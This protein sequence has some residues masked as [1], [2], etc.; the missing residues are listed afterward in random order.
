MLFAF[1][2][3]AP[4]VGPTSRM[5]QYA[6]TAWRIQ[7]GVFTGA[8]LSITQT[9]DGYIWIGTQTGL[10]RFDGVRF[11]PW[12][13]PEGKRLLSSNSIFSLLADR[14]GSLWIGTGTDLAHWV[15]GDLV[16][17]SNARGRINA[18]RQD[19]NGTVWITRS[20]VREATGPLCEVRGAE[21]VCHGS[22][23]GFQFPFAQ[24]LALD[25]E[26]NYWV[27]GSSSLARWRAGSATV[28]TPVSLKG[29]AGLSGVQGLAAGP[30]GT[31]WVGMN[32]A[33]PGLGL[34]QF[35]NGAWAPF[36]TEGFDGSKLAVTALF[37]DRSN[38]L[39]IG[40]DN[41]GIYRIR[42]GKVDGFSSADG[43]SSDTVQSFYE[44]REGDLW[45]VTSEGIDCFRSTRILSFSTR[46]GLTANEVNSVI[47]ARDGNVWFGNQGALDYLRQ[48]Q[49][50]SIRPDRG[51]PGA[52]VTAMM[53]DHAGQLWVGVDD[54]LWINHAGKFSAVKHADGVPTGAVISLAEDRNNVVWALPVANPA[55]LLRIEGLV[56]QD[57]LAEAKLPRISSLATDRAEGIW[58]GLSTGELTRY[59][60]GNLETYKFNQTEPTAIRQLTV[61]AD[62][63]VW[64]STL[65]GLVVWKNGALRN[66]RVQN[67]LPCDRIF[68]SVTDRENDLW[69]YSECGLVRID[70][71]ELNSWWENPA[72]VLHPRLFDVFDG[73]RPAIPAFQ[74]IAS[75]APDGRLWFTNETIA[76]VIDPA[77][78]EKNELP[79]PVHI[80][81][82]VANRQSYGLGSKIS[83][84]PRIRDLQIDYTALSFVVPQKVL[85]RYKLEGHD[86][87]WQDA[88]TRRQAFYTD[89][90]PGTYRFHVIACNNDGVW[91]EVG[92]VLEFII[93]PAWYQTIWFRVLAVLA[94]LLA[95]FALYRLRVRQIAHGITA[96]YDE[97]LAERTRLARELHDTF[98]QTIQGSKMVADDA[99]DRPADAVRLRRVVEQLS[100]WLGQAV[101][102]GRAALNS[103][104]A[105][106]VEQN[107]LAAALRRATETCVVAGRMDVAFVVTGEAREMHPIVRDEIYRI[108]F[109]AIRNACAHSGANKL[110]VALAYNHDVVVRVTD[111][112]AGIDPAVVAD[113]KEGHF[114]LPGMRERALRIGAEL[115]ISTSPSVGTEINLVVPGGLAFQKPAHPS[116]ITR[117]S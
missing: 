107:D 43:L 29:A 67:G 18:I 30:D 83:L 116:E 90:R 8:P 14:D 50:G 102:E 23:E 65:D 82:V 7:N 100:V 112:G 54:G 111:N 37:F 115:T 35:R 91:N 92:D 9:N 51:L 46:E 75:L 72:I 68:G 44:D 70:H 53:E 27:G 105:S 79:P 21:L 93:A 96:L 11:A 108:G 32:R 10:V 66:L 39:W 57:V 24:P 78:L 58:L 80:E 98:L 34:Q 20:R 87:D 104:R 56:A 110:G 114:G 3:P 13:P 12:K 22:S 117:S 62:G 25:A 74:P 1:V 59:R 71:G 17:Y 28:Y 49:S 95:I 97:R 109:E 15:G 33:G 73:A 16:N 52:S 89:L 2:S 84:P 19:V 101:E 76:Q 113:G 88:G 36:V 4:A 42:D 94:V 26:G 63:S 31:L 38:T 81:A 48:G 55:R 45:V 77:Q 61:R 86:P 47:A 103:L 6:H 106:T 99:L 85:F 60:S 69:L 41:Q 40:T 5:T 64:G